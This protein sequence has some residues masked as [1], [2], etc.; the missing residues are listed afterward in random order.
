MM[1]FIQFLFG[2]LMTGL[3]AFG[4]GVAFVP[5]LEAFFTQIFAI[6]PADQFFE[7]VGYASA[8][9]GPLGAKIVGAVGYETF[10]LPGLIFGELFFDGPGIILA[11]LLYRLLMKNRQQPKLQAVTQFIQPFIIV[12]VAKVAVSLT[13]TTIATMEIWHFF[14]IFGGSLFLIMKKKY[15]PIVAIIFAICYGLVFLP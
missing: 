8:L 12:M 10:G 6:I 14:I 11:L 15:P 1:L 9:P 5:M 3:T 4:G 7:I 2:A 13:T